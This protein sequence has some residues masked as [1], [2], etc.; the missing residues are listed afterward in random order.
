MN[1]CLH[2]LRKVDGIRSVFRSIVWNVRST[3]PNVRSTVLNGHS[4]VRNGKIIGSRALFRWDAKRSFPWIHPF[5]SGN[6]G[7]KLFR[8]TQCLF[9][10]LGIGQDLQRLLQDSVIFQAL[11][12][13]TPLVVIPL[14][15]LGGHGLFHLLL[16]AVEI[17]L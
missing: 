11:L 14:D 9:H 8:L 7:R 10:Q 17:L 16:E 13:L 12:Q 5:L 15:N 1:F 3:Q 6:R 2:S 4:A